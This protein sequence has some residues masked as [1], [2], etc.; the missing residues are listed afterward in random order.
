MSA[1]PEDAISDEEEEKEENTESESVDDGLS[2]TSLLD[3]QGETKPEKTALSDCFI[4]Y[5]HYTT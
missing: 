2:N 4:N 1:L 5:L 3:I